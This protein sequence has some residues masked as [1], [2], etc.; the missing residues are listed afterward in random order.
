VAQD[1]DN[2]LRLASRLRHRQDAAFLLVGTGSEVSRLEGRVRAEGLANVQIH[3]ARPQA[4]YAEML[5]EFDVGLVTL[6]RRLKS[7]NVPGKLMGYL[8][9]GMP[10]LAS[11]N[12]DNDLRQLLESAGAGLCSV[13]GE[14][15]LLEQNALR[16]LEDS[17]LR[18]QMGANGRRLLVEE[19][20]VEQAADRVLQPARE[21]RPRAHAEGAATER[22]RPAD[23]GFP[24]GAIAAMGLHPPRTEGTATGTP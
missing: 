21:R 6:D 9:A 18:T 17:A 7:R 1:M 15:E 4:E 20:S 16:L 14:D 24:R 2:V 5:A 3:P 12:P 23:A 19:F 22:A 8:Q 10:V 13:N 11:L